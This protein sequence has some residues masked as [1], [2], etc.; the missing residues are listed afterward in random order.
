MGAVQILKARADPVGTIPLPE[1]SGLA[2][3]R[4]QDGRPMLVAVGD[5]AARIAWA[6]VDRGFRELRWETVDLSTAQG[7]AI[8]TEDPQL[9]ALAVDG[10]QGILLVQ[11]YPNRAELVDAVSRR[12]RARIE[13]AVPDGPGRS[14]LHR[15]WTDPHGS[16]AEGVV[17]LRDGHLLV[18]KE[19]DPP[20]LLE[21]GPADH[22]PGGLGP[23][24]W[25]APD[26]PWEVADGEATLVLLAAWH[27]GAG[28]RA[29]C[30]DL[31]D[32]HVDPAGRL[33]LLSDQGRALLVVPPL[34]PAADPWEGTFEVEA[35]VR[36]VGVVDKPEGLV[37]LPDGDVLLACDRRKVKRNLYAV[38]RA[39][40]APSP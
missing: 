34:P 27:A 20:T 11:E 5:R 19:K 35:L 7:T 1:V 17:L 36:L 12:V 10:A 21:F 40:W 23:R 38:A 31:S 30:P 37:V 24:T 16:H 4:G 26:A 39:A 9:E 25:L 3:G 33:V 18:V 22:R 29:E 32:A 8:P 2:L 14:E 28:L 13:L 6:P 15:A